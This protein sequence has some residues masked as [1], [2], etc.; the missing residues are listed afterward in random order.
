MYAKFHCVLY[1]DC[2]KAVSV[3]Y[4]PHLACEQTKS[5]DAYAD[6]VLV[7]AGDDHCGDIQ[8][9]TYPL[10]VLCTLRLILRVRA[11][12]I[13]TV[14]QQRISS[15]IIPYGCLQNATCIRSLKV[16]QSTPMTYLVHAM[17]RPLKPTRK[18]SSV[19]LLSGFAIPEHYYC[20]YHPDKIWTHKHGKSS[21]TVHHV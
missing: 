8:M 2:S 16:S 5:Q 19:P 10:Y 7:T 3:A 1:S 13:R 11:R 15:L 21:F 20:M 12:A 14:C 4:H 9:N 17:R 6:S 18:T